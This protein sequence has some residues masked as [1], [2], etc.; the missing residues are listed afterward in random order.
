MATPLNIVSTLLIIINNIKFQKHIA[1]T[2]MYYL[3]LISVAACDKIDKSE[4]DRVYGLYKSQSAYS[5]RLLLDLKKAKEECEQKILSVEKREGE[6]TRI[7]SQARVAK[8]ELE[9]DITIYHAV[10][11]YLNEGKIDSAIAEAKNISVNSISEIDRKIAELIT[12]LNRQKTLLSLAQEAKKIDNKMAS[13]GE[14]KYIY[15]IG[16][17]ATVIVFLA[18]ICGAI[19][20]IYKLIM[21]IAD[22][23]GRIS[24]TIV[25]IGFI[26]A[27]M[28][29]LSGVK[30]PLDIAFFE[31]ITN[32]GA[33]SVGAVLDNKYYTFVFKIIAPLAVGVYFA[34]LIQN[35]VLSGDRIQ[36]TN[37]LVGLTSMVLIFIIETARIYNISDDEKGFSARNFSLIFG[38][39]AAMW[40]TRLKVRESG[41]EGK[42]ESEVDK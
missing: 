35:V 32:V 18:I 14:E 17:T 24:A 39:V 6:V 3:I 1:K 30:G 21:S 11:K 42:R 5:E 7:C 40:L 28:S 20:S 19:L 33:D 10:I 31:A 29:L 27:Y 2:A 41:E 38:F 37:L 9:G 23:N 15:L 34:Y 25:S 4:Y 22:L 12:S 8:S 26:A 13:V 16:K 36:N